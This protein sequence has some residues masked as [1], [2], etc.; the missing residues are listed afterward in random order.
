M[1]STV[2]PASKTCR[3]TKFTPRSAITC[4]R[5]R[6]FRGRTIVLEGKRH[7][8]SYSDRSTQLR[9]RPRVAQEIMRPARRVGDGGAAQVDAEMAIDAR[10]HVVRR[11]RVAGRTFAASVGGADD[12]PGA[13]AAAG[14]HREACLRPVV[15]PGAAVDAW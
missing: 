5:V 4:S 3:S 9:D 12:L 2:N 15:P 6:R 1:R 7:L 13:P 11:V 14:H 10:Q 8:E